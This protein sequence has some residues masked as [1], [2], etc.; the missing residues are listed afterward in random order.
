MAAAIHRAITHL[1]GIAHDLPTA[2]SRLDLLADMGEIEMSKN[3][4]QIRSEAP[5]AAVGSGLP[6]DRQSR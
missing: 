4:Q 5:W 2:R 3:G 6:S 1:D